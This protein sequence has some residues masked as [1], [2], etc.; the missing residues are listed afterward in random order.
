MKT[1]SMEM[2]KEAGR[3]ALFAAATA[4]LGYFAQAITSLDPNSLYYVLGTVVLRLADKYIH[5][6]QSINANGL[7]P[8]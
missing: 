6:K 7:A 3:I 4:L 5:E 1:A 8:F 2:A